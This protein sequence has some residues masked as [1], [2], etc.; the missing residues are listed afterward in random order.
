MNS[1]Q[2]LLDQPVQLTRSV[3]AYSMLYPCTDN[4]LD[5]DAKS[6]GEKR[7]FNDWV[8]RRI[9]RGSTVSGHVNLDTLFGLIETEHPRSKS[10]QVYESVMAIQIAQRQAMTQRSGR[11][12]L[13]DI[14]T[15]SFAK[16]G[17]SVMAHGYLL[18][19]HISRGQAAFLFGF[20][21]FLQLLDDLQDLREDL[22]VN[23]HTLFTSAVIGGQPIDVVVLKLLH[24]MKLV[25]ERTDRFS[26]VKSQVIR[27]LI[28]RNCV[29]L[30]LTAVSHLEE[31]CSRELIE[32]LEPFAPL[33]FREVRDLNVLLGNR[34]DRV[35]RKLVDG[36]KVQSVWNVLGPMSP[37]LWSLPVMKSI[38]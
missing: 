20:G 37:Q 31:F 3:F 14:L 7:D 17:T 29:L 5:D 6:A 16:G 30:L 15:L 9:N 21:V 26:S 2:M 34:Y 27:Q 12:D 18:N 10:P 32:R 1:I 22:K 11:L 19:G 36:K 24:F 25:L 28:W 4:F 23:H 13:A 35:R 33:S 38:S 8:E